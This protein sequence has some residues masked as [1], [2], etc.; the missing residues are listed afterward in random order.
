MEE[1]IFS[2]VIILFVAMLM[3]IIGV[4]QIM[5][6]KPV[7]FYSGEKPPREDE[8]L[9]IAMW[10]KKHGY[11]WVIYGVTMICSFI[12]SSLV[13]SDTIAMV[14]LL[15]DIIG[16]LPIMILYHNYLKKKYYK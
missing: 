8:L 9:D 7:G 12:F 13:K 3:I 5:S 11:M 1:Y 2:F 14:V 4:S 15:S 16:A 10:N 6:K